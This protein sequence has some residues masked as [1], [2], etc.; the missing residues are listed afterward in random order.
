MKA[1][2]SIAFFKHMK[3]VTEAAWE[4][5]DLEDPFAPRVQP[6]TKWKPG[7]SEQDPEFLSHDERT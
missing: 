7:L 2:N 3:A 5:N 1:D 6:G 4:H